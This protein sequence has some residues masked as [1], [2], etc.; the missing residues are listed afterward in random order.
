MSGESNDGAD[1]HERLLGAVSDGRFTLDASCVVR[2]ADEAFCDLVGHDRE[3]VVDE[4]L[5]TFLVAEGRTAV[6]RH[7]DSLVDGDGREDAPA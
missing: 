6:E 5:S 2:D 3:A 7:V 4:P 1:R